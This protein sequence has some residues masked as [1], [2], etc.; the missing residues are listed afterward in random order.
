MTK[1][2]IINK[3]HLIAHPEGGY[4]KET[5]KSDIKYNNNQ[6]LYSSI[7][8]LLGN[9]DISHL[10]ELDEDEL[11]YYQDG[12]SLIIVDIYLDENSSKYIVKEIKLGKDISNN[13]YIQYLVKKNHIFGSYYINDSNNNDNNSYSL[14]G[15][16]VSPS[17]SY[18]HFRLIKKEEL[19]DKLDKESFNK[20]EFMFIE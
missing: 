2:E 15:C 11:W 4:F 10:H 3:Y 19:K 6:V 14:V 9:N 12:N 7:L 16:M 8:F 20:Y 5:Y 1:K 18:D 13:E 17:F